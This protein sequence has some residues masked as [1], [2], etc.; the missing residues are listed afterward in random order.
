MPHTIVAVLIRHILD[1]APA[2]TV[3]K[4]RIDIGHAH[5]FR[6][7]EA[8]E[9]QVKLERINVCNTDNVGDKRTCR[10]TTSRP[11]GNSV[12]TRPVDEVPHDE[13]VT[14]H[15]HVA[16]TVE[17]LVHALGHVGLVRRKLEILV[18]EAP[19]Q[20][21]VA[22]VGNVD[23][24]IATRLAPTVDALVPRLLVIGIKKFRLRQA[25]Y[26]GLVFF[27]QGIFGYSLVGTI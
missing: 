13:Q 5:A 9:K 7:Q 8:F 3:S 1:N 26:L 15:V 27:R 6:V 23:I 12:F 17:F 10:R 22:K 2:V 20:T 11:H 14:R 16:D 21:L 18:R 25:F 4:V 19:F 24:G